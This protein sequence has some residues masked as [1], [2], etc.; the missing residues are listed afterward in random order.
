LKS[1]TID[2][3]RAFPAFNYFVDYRTIL[4]RLFRK[5]YCK[6]NKR[7]G[8]EI[9]DTENKTTTLDRIFHSLFRDGSWASRE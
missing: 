7:I 4:Q 3:L 9:N 2:R 5:K 6:T 8:Y 1:K